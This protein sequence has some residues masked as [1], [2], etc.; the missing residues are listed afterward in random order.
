MSDHSTF[1]LW[2]SFAVIAAVSLIPMNFISDRRTGRRIYWWGWL[3]G[4]AGIAVAMSG[5]EG[6]RAAIVGAGG[7][8]V[9]G[10]ITAFRYTPYLKVGGQIFASSRWDRQPDPGDQPEVPFRPLTADDVRSASF[11]RPFGQ[12][13]YNPGEV[14]AFVEMIAGRLE[15]ANALTAD[16]IGGVKFGRPRAFVRG[17]DPHEVDEFLAAAAETLARLD[18]FGEA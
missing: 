3:M 16:D 12:Q 13:G 1:L 5:R 17:Y 7:L 11:S 6:W 4:T 9:I 14:D 18:S 15:R 2:A 10:V 8:F